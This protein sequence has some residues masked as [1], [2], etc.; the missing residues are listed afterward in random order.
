MT[1]P[2]PPPPATIKSVNLGGGAHYAVVFLGTL[3]HLLDQQHLHMETIETFGGSSAGGIIALMLL[4]GLT[5]R[6]IF[7]EVLN[8][9]LEDIFLNDMNPLGLFQNNG[10]CLGKR[11]ID[12]VVTIVQM[13]N[14]EF[15][16]RTTFETLFTQTNKTLVVS[17]TNLSA[18][19]VKLF[20][21]DTTP[22]M[23]VMY[24]I[25]LSVSIP[26]LFQSLQY[27]GDTYIDGAWFMDIRDVPG[28]EKYFGYADSLHFFLNLPDGKEGSLIDLT[29]LIRCYHLENAWVIDFG[30]FKNVIEVQVKIT[31]YSRSDL[32]FLFQKGIVEGR[33]YIKK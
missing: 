1:T 5:P 22:K 4:V 14:K 23:S 30:K 13:K 8:S 31:N 19:S 11:L 9:D 3:H 20:S 24:A 10:L 26:I 12:R 21:V 15:H 6:E 2:P 16:A 27:K 33:M 32:L 18:K 29:N 25:R 17:G 7:T 28:C